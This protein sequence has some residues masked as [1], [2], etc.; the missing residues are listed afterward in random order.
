MKKVSVILLIIT[1]LTISAL[2]T[3]TAGKVMDRILKRGELI[4]GIT[5]TQ[6]PPQCHNQGRQDHRFRRRYCEA[7]SRKHGCRSKI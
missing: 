5:G 6:P 3:A 7:D 4:V 2:D 1:V